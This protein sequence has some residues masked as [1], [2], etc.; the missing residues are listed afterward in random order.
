VQLFAT[1]IAGATTL[2]SE[3]VDATLPPEDPTAA[4]DDV[5]IDQLVAASGSTVGTRS[6]GR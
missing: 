5:I 4:S 6:R 3:D 1:R 2:R